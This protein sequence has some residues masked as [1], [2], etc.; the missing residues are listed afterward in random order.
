MKRDFSLRLTPSFLDGAL[1]AGGAIPDAVLVYCGATCID[2]RARHTIPRHDRGQTLLGPGSATR[3]VTTFTDDSMSPMGT[4]RVLE[5]TARKV[6][7]A[8]RPGLLIL[9][10]LS[11]VTLAGEDL[12]A[13]AGA[14]G[15]WFPSPVVAAVSRRLARDC[16]DA[17]GSVLCG[18][19]AGLPEEAFSR[20]LAADRVAL[21][22]Y[23]FDRHEG[24][25]TGDVAVLREMLGALGLK[26]EAPWLSGAGMAEL[27][28]AAGASVILALPQGLAAARLL[29]ARSGARVVPVDLPVGLG[30]TA[31]WLR[32]VGAAL[33]REGAAERYISSQLDRVVPRL[34][35][36]VSR[37]LEGRRAAVCAAPEWLRGLVPF[38]DLELGVEVGLAL[39]RGRCL[40]DGGLVDEN[41]P[42]REIDP[43]V[44]T[45]CAGLGRV[46]A[47]GGLDLVIGS[48][49]ER[50][51]AQGLLDGCG[52]VEF[53]YP[54][55]NRHFLSPAP[56]L[57]FEGALT[58]AERL[59]SE[60]VVR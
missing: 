17:F 60:C 40:P 46:R 41:D 6:L 45:L 52:W 1:L 23:F 14:I 59:A 30:G 49:W 19:A 55:L 38:L 44:E 28:A 22:G 42:A 53:G 57:G 54:S 29:A 27:S 32:R 48:S 8:R 13:T 34:E 5:E 12:K 9:A 51:S 15:A 20:G 37:E 33:G 2:E 47:A 7:A 26:L 11:C 56:H 10:E 39:P 24:D 50:R 35:W 43:S 31:A 58:W 21:L 4:A 18:I 25:R 36:V 16:A 3:L